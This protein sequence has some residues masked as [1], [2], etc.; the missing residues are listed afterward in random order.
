M[1]ESPS[2]RFLLP[3]ALA[4]STV[5]LGIAEWTVG[6][7]LAFRPFLAIAD[8]RVGPAGFGALAAH[9][10]LC[11]D[12]RRKRL[13]LRVGALLEIV[14]FVFLARAGI[15][16]DVI[17]FSVGYG[18][19]VAALIDFLFH[20][21]WRSAAIASLVPIGMASAPLGLNGVVRQL[22]P[23]TFDGALYA[24]D[25][26]L[27]IPFSRV[28]GEVVDRIPALRAMSLIVYATLPGAIAAG[29]AYEEYNYRRGLLRGVG[30]NLLLAYMVSGTLAALLYVICPGTG[31]Y[32]AFPNSFPSGLPD[33][34]SVPLGLAEF[35]PLSP[36]NAMP[37][38]HFAWAVL[39]W[40]SLR[41]A[42]RS[43]R[44]AAG[45]YVLLTIVATI[46]SG[47]H[48]VVDLI[49]ALPFVVALEAA[50]SHRFVP[51]YRRMVAFS[52]GMFFF[53]AWI[54]LVRLAPSVVPF[55]SAHAELVWVLTLVTVLSSATVALRLGIIPVARESRL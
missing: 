53:A 4:W 48:Y 39:L 31:P 15:R 9:G 52:V 10:I 42:R 35:A 49:A 5:A 20:H 3:A 12:D 30:V 44:V 8:P 34:A 50:T 19:F 38:L 21:E 36:R 7:G 46:G 43:L 32:H 40:R 54:I 47:E 41:G 24:L 27:R 55:L 18:F 23:L 51:L 2:R 26:T 16:L 17:A 1:I 22:T 33:P 13:V 11:A 14:R 25:G 28:A 45:T 6:S 37:S 29:L